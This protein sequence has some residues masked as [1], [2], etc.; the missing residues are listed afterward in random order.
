MGNPSPSHL[1]SGTRLEEMTLPESKMLEHLNAVS[2]AKRLANMV[3][4]LSY[5]C[6][7]SGS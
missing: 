5:F 4:Y 3:R 7:Y 1:G 2:T 6:P